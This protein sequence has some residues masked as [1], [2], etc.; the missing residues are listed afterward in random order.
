MRFCGILLALAVL[1]GF[2]S[3]K[4]EPIKIV[5]FGTSFTNGKGVPRDQSYPAQ[6]QGLLRNKGFDVQ[7]I[8]AGLDGDT[9][10]KALSRLNQAIPKDAKIVIVEFGIN[11][12]CEICSSP[13]VAEAGKP[14]LIPS[15]REIFRRLN[16][17]GV[18]QIILI[19]RMRGFDVSEAAVGTNVK[20]VAPTRGLNAPE[21]Q[22]GD[23]QLHVNGAAY[24]VVASRLLPHV[25]RAI[26]GLPK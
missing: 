22:I 19:N 13:R 1:F 6:L 20:L 11:E 14:H 10:V 21:Y 8:N 7:V 25:E 16:E 26:A 4:A 23:S 2:P 17:M 12:L 3:A 5:A 18:S 24:A 9:A 15:L